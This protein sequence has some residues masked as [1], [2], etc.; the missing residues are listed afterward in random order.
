MCEEFKRSIV[1]FKGL[2][3]KHLDE[4]SVIKP[5]IVKFS[6]VY[7]S[8]PARFTSPETWPKSTNLKCWNCDLQFSSYPRFIAM[9]PEYGPNKVEIYEVYGNFCEWNCAVRYIKEKMPPQQQN[10]LHRL[11]CIVSQ[12]FTGRHVQKIMP[13]PDKTRMQPYCGDHGLSPA[14]FRDEIAQL[15]SDYNLVN[16]KLEHMK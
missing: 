13:S 2:F 6:S 4:K 11:V 16:Y 5:A 9:N 8:I 10:D 15:N 3:L 1:I 12:K 7:D 14:Q